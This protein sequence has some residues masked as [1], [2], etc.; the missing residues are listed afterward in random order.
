[1]TPLRIA[2]MGTPGFSVPCLNEILAGGHDVVAVYTQPP[3]PA[4]RGQ[5][6]KKS[7]IHDLAES[8]NLTVRTPKTLKAKDAQSDFEALNLDV[9]IVVA[10]GLI[11]PQAILDAPKHGCINVHASLLPRW[12]GAA[13]IQRAIMAGDQETGVCTMQ[14]DAGLD[15]GDVL[16]RASAPITPTTTSGLLHDTL[17]QMGADLLRE[18][19]DS[20][21]KGTL[22]PKPQPDQGVTYADKIDKAE[23]RIDWSKPAEDVS[24]LIRGLSPFP[25]A[26]FELPGEKKPIRI[27]ALN[28][29][30]TD[31]DGPAGT[32]L[33][34][35]LVI[36]CGDKSVQLTSL[37]REGKKT[38][39]GEAFLRGLPVPKGAK[40]H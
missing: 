24:C 30:V 14:M 9:A 1:M 18:T 31:L 37:Q 39:T 27:K 32:A 7:P 22:S 21:V 15:T 4:G 26:W 13:P 19:L 29:V 5:S 35:D 20:L 2:F 10:Y 38:A 8:L 16:L 6:D 11:L 23:A 33:S 12:R 3:R 40:V 17:S 36:A 28:A 25:G 34:G